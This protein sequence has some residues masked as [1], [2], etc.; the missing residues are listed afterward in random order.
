MQ[1]VSEVILCNNPNANEKK[2]YWDFDMNNGD[3]NFQVDLQKCISAAL[4]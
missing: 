4:H 1:N 3:A 2:S